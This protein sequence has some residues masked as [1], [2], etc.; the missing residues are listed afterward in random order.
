MPH[1]VPARTPAI[2]LAALIIYAGIFVVPMDVAIRITFNPRNCVLVLTIPV[3]T[4]LIALNI[5]VQIVDII[6]IIDWYW[7]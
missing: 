6:G 5:T 1:S 4:A 7:Y 2:N 3:S